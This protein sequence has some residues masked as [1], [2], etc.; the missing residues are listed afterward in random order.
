MKAHLA[1]LACTVFLATISPAQ[2]EPAP[3][4]APRVE[5]T[6][7]ELVSR[8]DLWP[9]EV[10][11][12]KDIRL[13]GAPMMR[14]GRTLPLHE[15]AGQHAVLDGGDFLFDVPASDT[16]VVERA[17]TLLASLTPEQLAL[18][19]AVLSKHGDLW[20]L[21]VKMM[22]DITFQNGIGIPAGREVAFRGF[23]GGLPSVYDRESE[24]FFVVEPHETDLLAR[25]RARMTAEK[26]D[27]P[28]F[29]RALE[30]SLVGAAS[31]ADAAVARPLA[32]ADFI[33]VYGGRKSCSRCASFLPELVEFRARAKA[34][35]GGFE[36]VY[37]PK[38]PTADEAS[39]YLRENKLPF[40]AIDFD[41]RLEAACLATIPCQLLPTVFLFDR[42]GNLL[43]RNHENGGAPTG[44]DLL[45]DLEKRLKARP[46]AK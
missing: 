45:K 11:L 35:L 40:P 20:P 5:L 10:T 42:A 29:V 19:W 12:R 7:A 21:R 8:R 6:L 9:S 4:P 37:L 34:E 30:A 1:T 41:R 3:P 39:A 44:R 36:I 43:A 25:S 26:P 38:D 13:S 28:F 16:D 14:A 27:E 23:E 18:S 17:R 33:L 15:L 24:T 31:P 22:V 2:N 32:G 46:A